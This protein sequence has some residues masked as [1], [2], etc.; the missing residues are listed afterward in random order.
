MFTQPLEMSIDQINRFGGVEVGNAKGWP[1]GNVR[2][3]QLLTADHHLEYRDAV[4]EPSTVWL[5]AVAGLLAA[6]RTKRSRI[7]DPRDLW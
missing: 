4:P 1:N 2:P 5:L 3:L 7:A 6:R